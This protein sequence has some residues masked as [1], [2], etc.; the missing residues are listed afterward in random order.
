M[1]VLETD[2]LRLRRL[3]TADAAFILALLNEPSWLRFIGDKGVRTLDDARRYILSGPMDSYR[4]LG[5][6]MY[7]V[8]LKDGGTLIGIC[9]LVKRD[10]LEDVDIGFAFLPQFWGMGYAYESASAVMAFGRN[11]LGL[12]RIVAVTAPDNDGSVRVLEK[13]GLRFHKAVR[14]SEDDKEISLFASGP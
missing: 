2:R 12:S 11:V 13:L 7:L 3:S 9:G 10:S 4:R 14:L 6:G 1:T 5:F 8:E